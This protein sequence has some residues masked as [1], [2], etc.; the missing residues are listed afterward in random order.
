MRVDAGQ[1]VVAQDAHGRGLTRDGD[2]PGGLGVGRVADVDEADVA[3]LAVRVDEQST[4][5]R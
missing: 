3:R 1:G 5:L 4:V 2:G